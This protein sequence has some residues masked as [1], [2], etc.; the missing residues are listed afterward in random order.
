M[1]MTIICSC[2]PIARTTPV[3]VLPALLDFVLSF[4]SRCESWWWRDAKAGGF[5]R[6]EHAEDLLGRARVSFA[7]WTLA[8]DQ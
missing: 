8:R 5:Q 1:N 4:S 7:S 2:S 3:Q 6:D